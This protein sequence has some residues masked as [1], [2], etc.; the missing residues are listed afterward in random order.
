[1]AQDT[2]SFMGVILIGLGDRLENLVELVEM[3]RSENRNVKQGG[4]YGLESS[5]KRADLH[6]GLA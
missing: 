1:M 2:P 4:L 3:C 6:F 5:E